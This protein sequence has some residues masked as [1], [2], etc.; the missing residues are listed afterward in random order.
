VRL[1]LKGKRGK[2]QG[3]STVPEA[4]DTTKSGVAAK[5]A[6]GGNRHLE[7][8]DDQRKLG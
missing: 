3:G 4:D 6:E 1:F 7:V 2:R 8:G 5:E